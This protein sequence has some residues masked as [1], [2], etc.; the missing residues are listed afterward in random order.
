MADKGAAQARMYRRFAGL[1]EEARIDFRRRNVASLMVRGMTQREI[2]EALARQGIL[3]PETKK[4]YSLGTVNGDC[5]YWR[6]KWLEEAMDDIQVWK[7]RLLA[8]LREARRSA[9]S[10]GDYK[11]VMHGIKQEEEMYGLGEPLAVDITTDGQPLQRSSKV[12][13]TELSDDELRAILARRSK[14]GTGSEDTGA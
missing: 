8:E 14:G 3:N 2:Q 6:D 13:Y 12:D 10:E 5:Q 4:P 9:W 1:S 11:A 7:A